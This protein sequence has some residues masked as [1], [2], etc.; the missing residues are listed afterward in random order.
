MQGG[1]GFPNFPIGLYKY[2]QKQEPN[3]LIDYIG[4]VDVVDVDCL[5]ALSKA[6]S[7]V[8]HAVI[9]SRKAEVDQFMEGLGPL[10]WKIKNHPEKFEP[11][12]VAGAC[13]PPLSED[14]FSIVD[15]DDVDERMKEYFTRYVREAGNP[16]NLDF[17]NY[18]SSVGV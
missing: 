14:L 6:I 15:Y 9:L 18:F 16:C 11:L 13:E 17:K 7:L 4:K 3:D 8:L 10:L 1:P 5:D 12:F 2:F